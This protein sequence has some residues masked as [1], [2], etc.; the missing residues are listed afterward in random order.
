[1]I[2]LDTKPTTRSLVLLILIAA[3]LYLPVI[4]LPEVRQADEALQGAFIQDVV[5]GGNWWQT[6]LYGQPVAAFPLYSWVGAIC[7]GLRMPTPFT[8]R[9]PTVLALIGLALCS[10]LFASRSQSRYAGYFAAMVV[11]TCAISFRTGI[12]A[13]CETIAAFLLACGW[14][15]LYFFGWHRNQWWMG[16]GSALA[17][18]FLAQLAIGFKAPVIFYLPLLFLQNGFRTTDRLESPP[19]VF[20]AFLFCLLT[21]IWLLAVP[22]QPYFPWSTITWPIFVA[23]GNHSYLRHLVTMLPFA[24]CYLFPWTLFA[25]G[26]FCLALRQF[27]RNG[28][29]CHYLRVIVLSNFLF[30]WLLP[31]GSPLHLLPVL[32]PMAILIGTHAEIIIRRY[33]SFWSKLLRMFS[34]IALVASLFGMLLALAFYKGLL[35]CEPLRLGELCFCLGAIG[36]AFLIS[37]WQLLLDRRSTYRRAFLLSIASCQMLSLVAIVFCGHHS[38]IRRENGHILAENCPKNST[39]YLET[40]DSISA[41]KLLVE[42]FYLRT[43][44][45]ACKDPNKVFETLPQGEHYLLSTRLPVLSDYYLV[46]A[47]PKVT[48]GERADSPFSPWSTHKPFL[49][50]RRKAIPSPSDAPYLQLFRVKKK[51][52]ESPPNEHTDT[53]P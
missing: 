32:G 20:G 23:N 30:F 15:L 6:H 7:S 39:V 18:V 53:Q 14:Y 11:L 5:A 24:A 16:W 1:M 33:R 41:G 22:E 37:V 34:L 43:H 4:G 51:P 35:S 12:R 17:A 3:L 48:L 46:E 40:P 36:V 2:S 10:G 27:E 21:V 25:W 50:I 9:L 13:Q 45:V 28:K 8:L 19:H 38:S 47:S 44:I 52:T 49:T 26:P 42:T 29:F 31:G